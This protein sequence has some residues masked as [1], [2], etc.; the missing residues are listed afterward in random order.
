MI[1]FIIHILLYRK[2]DNYVL[3]DY[4]S[5][6]KTTPV[7]ATSSSPAPPA[8]PPLPPGPISTPGASSSATLPTPPAPPPPPLPGD[9]GSR[10]LPANPSSS[11]IGNSAY[12]S[13]PLHEQSAP[14][15]APPLPPIP[16][17]SDP[18]IEKKAR[19]LPE[20]SNKAHLNKKAPPPQPPSINKPAL[21][22]PMPLPVEE[23]YDEFNG[24]PQVIEEIYD[25]GPELDASQDDL[26]ATDYINVKKPGVVPRYTDIDYRDDGINEYVEMASTGIVSPPGKVTFGTNELYI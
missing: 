25:Y 10:T 21:K 17:F 23:L 24:Q 14:P 8:P 5:K 11:Q 18:I 26:L 15:P 13:L 1:S 16:G 9:A 7:V 22:P 4:Q 19:P 6:N 2:D 20:L 12:K 3:E